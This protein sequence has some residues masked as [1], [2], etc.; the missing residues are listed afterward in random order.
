MSGDQALP[1]L[2]ISDFAFQP[3][4]RERLEAAIGGDHLVLVRG[5]GALRQ[6]LETHP[7]ADVV[8][9]FFPPE[10]VYELVPQLRW[11]A[12][13]SAGAD[14]VIG[15][16]LVRATGPVVTTANGVHAVPISE[17]V[18]STMLMWSRHWPHMLDMKRNRTWAAADERIRLRGQELFGSML[19]V[20]GLG[21]IGR[22]IAQ[23][24]RAFGMRVLAVRRSVAPG[25][26]D[27]DVDELL[28]S[29]QLG[30][31]L[32]NSDYVVVSLPSTRESHHLLGAEQ[33]RQMKPTAFLINIARGEII[34]EQ[35]LIQ[36]LQDGTIAGAALDVFENEPL[37]GE[38]PLWA[39]PNVIMSSHV[40]G[41]SDRYS[42]RL[43]DL[44]LDNLARFREGRPLRNVVDPARGY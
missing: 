40:S 39:L 42:Q 20:I 14:H 4:D 5:S 43:T 3:P 31:L 27:R 15:A 8:C 10:N 41:I 22:R 36:A 38:S 37:P 17:Y 26:T 30:A 32:A 7:Q 44:L 35:A 34:D 24:G 23:L 16:G 18:L 25:D 1:N 13:A 29:T 28:P 9:T 6:A 19:G 12:L 21:A 2:F 33:L 11:I